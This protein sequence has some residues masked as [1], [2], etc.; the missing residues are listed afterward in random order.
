MKSFLKQLFSVAIPLTLATVLAVVFF[1]AQTGAQ[2]QANLM[3][4]LSGARARVALQPY[5]ASSF[6]AQTATGATSALAVDT[7][8]RTHN[9]QLIVT[10]GPAGCTYRLQGS[11]DGGT[12][13]FNISAADI[14]CTST[15]NSVTVD[16]PAIRVRG[17][18]LTLSG[19]TSPTVRLHYVG[20][21]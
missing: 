8:A 9:S 10:G 1:S 19:G 14:T 3:Y 15:T 20:A 17:N 11:N 7:G 16:V 21:Q 18:L 6:T 5:I 13:W 2:T 4:V 12:T